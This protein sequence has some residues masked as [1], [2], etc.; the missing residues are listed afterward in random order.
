MAAAAAA[1]AA[2]KDTLNKRESADGGR[3]LNNT[4]RKLGKGIAAA[5]WQIYT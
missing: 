3:D 5:W 4:C 1:V 2:S